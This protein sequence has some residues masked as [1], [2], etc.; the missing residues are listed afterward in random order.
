MV[1][2]LI[3][4]HSVQTNM[5]KGGPKLKIRGVQV[6]QVTS[7]QCPIPDPTMAVFPYIFSIQHSPSKPTEIVYVHGANEEFR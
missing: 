3:F 5:A 6:C 4:G 7:D 1:P 2:P